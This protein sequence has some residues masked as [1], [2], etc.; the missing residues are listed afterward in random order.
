MED[1]ILEKDYIFQNGNIT[2]SIATK[3][4]LNT[5][6]FNQESKKICLDTAVQKPYIFK[7]RTQ[8]KK[9]KVI[10]NRFAGHTTISITICFLHAFSGAAHRCWHQLDSRTDPDLKHYVLATKIHN[11][12]DDHL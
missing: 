10:S 8:R 4:E 3:G 12:K 9:Y 5:Y 2:F 1:Q 7:T 11:I 6:M